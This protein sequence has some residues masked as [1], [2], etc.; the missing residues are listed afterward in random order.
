MSELWWLA[1]AYLLL[2][3]LTTYLAFWADKEKARQQRYRISESKLL[4]LA[5]LGG[6][7]GA[8]IAQHHLHHKTKTQPFGTILL[9]IP[10][11]QIS[12]AIGLVLST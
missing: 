1:A 10:L 8:I 12:V 4:L 7:L 9:C 2:I 6:S 3:N 11:I 5:I